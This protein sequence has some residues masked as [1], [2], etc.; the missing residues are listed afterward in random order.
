MAIARDA[1]TGLRQLAGALAGPGWGVAPQFV[2]QGLVARLRGRVRAL[3]AGGGFRPAAVG[4]GPNRA[5]RPQIRGDRLSW[6]GA[7][8]T[9]AEARL[10]ARF[11]LLRRVLNR[12]LQ[13]GLFDFECHYAIYGPGAAYARHL[14]RSPAGAERVVSA[15]L[16]LSADWHPADGGELRLYAET[17][18]VTVLPRAG[19]LVLFLSERFEH[20]VQPA[21][22]LRLSLAGW[23]CRRPRVG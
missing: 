18:P 5:V 10:L 12:E 23:F 4:A 13:L 15:V 6:L 1:A 21:G 9:L 8:H 14:D 7:P 11:E 22:R 3:E 19:S 16:Y 20:E 2:P 17:G